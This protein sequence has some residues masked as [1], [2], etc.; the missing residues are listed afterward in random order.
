MR[1]TGGIWASRRLRGPSKK[2]KIRPTP[3]AMRER[4]F[5]VIGAVVDGAVVLDLFSGSGAVGIEALS[6]GAARVV[7]VDAHHSSTTLIRGNLDSLEAPDGA[8]R[9]IQ[10]PAMRAVG[11]LAR[12]REVFDLVWADP[13][14]ESW[15]DGLDALAAAVSGGLV[16]EAAVLCLECPASAPVESL[17]PERLEIARDLKGGASRVVMLRIAGA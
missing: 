13:P 12:S 11:E 7:F 14:F 15:R 2:Q 16:S 9:V 5:A 17:L 3:D 8:A 6:R 4:A 10:R 1:V